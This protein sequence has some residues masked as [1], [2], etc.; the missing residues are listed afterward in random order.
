MDSRRSVNKRDTEK[1]I[2]L[3]NAN[4]AGDEGGGSIR[5][6]PFFQTVSCVASA[7]K[8]LM[9]KADVGVRIDCQVRSRHQGYKDLHTNQDIAGQR[10][11]KTLRKKDKK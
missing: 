9:M 1:V 4:A 3:S 6:K 2:S 5:S 11:G 8:H 10:G 7:F